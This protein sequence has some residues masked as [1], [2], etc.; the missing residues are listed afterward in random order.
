MKFGLSFAKVEEMKCYMITAFIIIVMA[1]GVCAAP[2]IPATDKTM[3]QELREVSSSVT[4]KGLVMVIDVQHEDLLGIRYSDESNFLEKT[5]SVVAEAKYQ[6]MDA[7]FVELRNEG[8]TVPELLDI[9]GENANRFIKNEYN[10]FANEE[11]R[12]FVNNGGYT[13]VF[14]MGHD[15]NV[16]VKCTIAGGDPVGPM[17]VGPGGYPHG[18]LDNE[19]IRVHMSSNTTAT[20]NPNATGADDAYVGDLYIEE[21]PRLKVYSDAGEISQGAMNQ[22]T[23]NSNCN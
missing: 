7:T 16:C 2:V 19:S 18:L 10:A 20:A 21:H 14:V 9:Y 1:T 22:L 3:I 6:E 12:D 8:E 4:R 5:Q 11:L 13:D 15:G 17:D 23:E